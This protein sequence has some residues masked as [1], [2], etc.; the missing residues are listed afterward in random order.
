MRRIA[1][2]GAGQIGLLTAHGLLKAGYD[3]TLFS[4]RSADDWLHRSRPTGT[5]ARFEM[6]L[7]YDRALG[8]HH[9]DDVTPPGQ[10]VHV[11]FCQ[12]PGNR[13]VTL[14][15]RLSRPFH[16]IDVRLQSHRWMHDFEARGGRLV[17]ESVS[18][19]RLD[20]IAAEHALTI[21]AAGKAEIGG[22]FARDDA[23]SVYTSPQRQL[24]M[25]VTKGGRLGFDGVPF[26]PVKFN[27]YASAGEAFW[28][29]Y[30]HKD[31]GPS[32]NLL[33]EAKKGGPMDRFGQVKSGAEAL[34]V[35]KQVIRDLVPWDY[36]WAKDM[37]LADENGWLTGAFTPVVK[38][39]VGTLPSGRVVTAVGDTAVLMDPIA[40]QGANSGTKMA[41]NLVESVIARGDRPFDA[42][43]MKATFEAYWERHGRHIT[44]FTN[45]LLEP[46]TA[47][48]QELLIAQYGS[49][50]ALRDGRQAIADAFI[51]NFDDPATLTPAFTDM[52]RARDFITR[53]TG[54]SWLWS[55]ARGRA[56]VGREQLRQ[57]LGLPPEHPRVPGAI[58][59]APEGATAPA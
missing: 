12:E 16:A 49:T 58:Y 21:V 22:L 8:L 33:F 7:A 17:I 25:I 56:L 35:A 37:E 10:G 28:V 18:I 6:A 26:L 42:A 38:N 52:G 40:G 59:Q 2:V 30:Y 54:R 14:A 11:T 15:G 45:L 20:A 55:A 23:R 29:P 27:L 53:S 50:G 43:W 34:D 3:V 32:W 24:A 9:W 51:E 57:K 1:V 47:P 39:P 44:A 5:A 48:G 31:V 41:R 13:L 19:P 36:A 46:L 4:D